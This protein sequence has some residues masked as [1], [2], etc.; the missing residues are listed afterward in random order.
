MIHTIGLSGVL[1]DEFVSVL[2]VAYLVGLPA[3]ESIP[4]GVFS[5]PGIREWMPR[6][7]GFPGARGM[8]QE[9]ITDDRAVN[10]HKLET[11]SATRQSDFSSCSDAN[12]SA[13]SIITSHAENHK[14]ANPS[15]SAD[16][17]LFSRPRSIDD[18]RTLTHSRS[19]KYQQTLHSSLFTIVFNE[20]V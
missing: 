12:S 8:T 14:L 13:V 20:T 9:E 3:R 4:G 11:T 16:I 15:Y 2:F 10:S 5:F 19:S 18:K 17:G 1:N 6:F 7:L